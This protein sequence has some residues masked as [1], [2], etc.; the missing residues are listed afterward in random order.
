MNKR[1]QVFVS[2]TFTDLQAERQEVMQ[3]LLELECIPAGM[4]LFPAANESQWALIKKVINDCDYYVLIIAGRYGSKSPRGVSY[5]EKEY[6]Y[7][8]LCKKPILA[9]LHKN[10][11]SLPDNQREKSGNDK[12]KLEKFRELVQKKS[13]R[14]W[15]S[16]KDLK[17]QVAASLANLIKSTPATGWIRGNSV[18]DARVKK[19][20]QS[21]KN[22][23]PID[24][25]GLQSLKMVSQATE[26]RENWD[27]L[28]NATT[29]EIKIA[30]NYS[31]RWL[32]SNTENIKKFLTRD[33]TS[34]RVI[35]PN[36]KSE[37][38]V[39]CIAKQ[40]ARTFAAVK[41]DINKTI[42]TFKT[43]GSK[44]SIKM[45]NRPMSYQLYMFDKIPVVLMF[46]LQDRGDT[47]LFPLFE[48][49]ADAKLSKSFDNDF[50]RIWGYR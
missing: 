46:P 21:Q 48:F 6:K 38:A 40:K 20:L 25:Y 36:P 10:T 39:S 3:A 4:E 11:D 7:A 14:Y 23:A 9:F 44:V 29:K 2:S 41:M 37:I 24:I 30:F 13:C 43:F 5:T 15:D 45:I 8:K 33:G 22:K 27:R 32:G 16:P 26:W 1:Y 42:D 17:G 47:Q 31:A 28:F 19:I 49:R 34:I 12:K 18:S 35:I 50:E